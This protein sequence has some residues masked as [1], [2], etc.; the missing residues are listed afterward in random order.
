MENLIGEL[1]NAVA[2]LGAP[3]VW[4]FA[5][6]LLSAA[7]VAVAIYVPSR[8]AKKQ[9]QIAVFDKLYTAYSQFLLVRS[10]SASIRTCS[11]TG[12]QHETLRNVDLFCVHFETAFGYRPDLRSYETSQMS[13]GAATSVLRK[14]ETQVY[15]LPMLISKSAE[16]KEACSKKI[17]AIYEPLFLLVTDVIMPAPD[18]LSEMDQ[19]LKD[20]VTATDAFYSEYADAIEAALMC[21]ARF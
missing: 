19:N 7:A 11:F 20:F 17:A 8:I 9:N 6:V 21:E 10:F 16:Q 13:I 14:S 3:T 12:E 15:M 2:K 4:D 5:P 1:I 18:E